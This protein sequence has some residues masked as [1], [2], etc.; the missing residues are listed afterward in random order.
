MDKMEIAAEIGRLEAELSKIESGLREYERQYNS[1]KDNR[2]AGAAALLFGILGILFLFN[3][4]PLW[5]F[6]GLIGILTL[7]T[8]MRKQGEAKEGMQESEIRI[9]DIRAKLAERRAQLAAF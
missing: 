3:L 9:A 1:A 8:A 4:W 2:T 6:L 5:G 7:L